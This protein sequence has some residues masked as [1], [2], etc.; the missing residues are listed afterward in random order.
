LLKVLVKCIEFTKTRTGRIDYV[1]KWS[2]MPLVGKEHKQYRRLVA[3]AKTIDLSNMTPRIEISFMPV[4][5]NKLNGHSKLFMFIGMKG[6][7]DIHRR[8]NAGE[9][10]SLIDVPLKTK[11]RV[12]IKSIRKETKDLVCHE[13]DEWFLVDGKRIF[14]PHKKDRK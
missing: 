4:L 1:V 6:I 13:I 12:L 14:D 2:E 10:F 8:P 9:V 5:Q 7:R 3:I 11:K